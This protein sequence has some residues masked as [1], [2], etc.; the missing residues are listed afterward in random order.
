MQFESLNNKHMFELT[1]IIE[2]KNEIYPEIS[3][4]IYIQSTRNLKKN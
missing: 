3:E 4:C 1:L 2:T